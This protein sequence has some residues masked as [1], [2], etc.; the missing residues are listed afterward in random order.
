MWQK[1]EKLISKIY[2]NSRIESICKADLTLKKY[3]CNAQIRHRQKP[4][5]ERCCSHIKSHSAEMYY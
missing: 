2:E 5:T 3:V 4:Q 1:V